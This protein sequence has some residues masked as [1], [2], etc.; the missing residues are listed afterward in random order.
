M[1]ERPFIYRENFGLNPLYVTY[2]AYNV[3]LIQGKV[4]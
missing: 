4:K 3:D 2:K 1:L